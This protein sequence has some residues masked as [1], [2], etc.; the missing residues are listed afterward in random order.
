M[1]NKKLLFSVLILSIFFFSACTLSDQKQNQII[2]PVPTQINQ[3]T[4]NDTEAELQQ[5]LNAD[6]DTNY[7]SDLNSLQ[8]ELNK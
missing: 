7:D 4:G 3:E 8:T 6:K 5:Q 2:T 1:K